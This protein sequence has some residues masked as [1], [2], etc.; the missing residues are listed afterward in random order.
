MFVSSAICKT[1]IAKVNC[2]K[3]IN[4]YENF[5]R[6]IFALELINWS[7]TISNSKPHIIRH[8]E[9]LILPHHSLER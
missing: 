9:F 8:E 1:N 2:L 3:L 6:H 5:G 4:F 7:S